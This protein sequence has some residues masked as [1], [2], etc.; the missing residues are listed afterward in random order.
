LDEGDHPLGQ[1]GGIETA[2]F[3]QNAELSTLT[4]P[5]DRPVISKTRHIDRKNLR[6]TKEAGRLVLAASCDHVVWDKLRGADARTL[7]SNPDTDKIGVFSVVS[8][9]FRNLLLVGES[10]IAAVHGKANPAF[11]LMAEGDSLELTRVARRVA[12]GD[13]NRFAVGEAAFGNF[14]DLFRYGAG[15]IKQAEGRRL[16]FTLPANAGEP[17]NV[18]VLS[19]H[20]R[21]PADMHVNDDAPR[22]EKPFGNV[23]SIPISLAPHA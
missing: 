1:L 22:I 17:K 5:D 6:Q 13:E 2:K 11:A 9:P 20:L 23:D 12:A 19:G 4:R 7:S 3:G 21:L 14:P 16:A 15:F 10:R 18:E 8:D